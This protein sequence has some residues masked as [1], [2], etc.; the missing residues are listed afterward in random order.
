MQR[1]L[2]STT[3]M[4]SHA[5]A[6][7]MANRVDCR[8]R[9]EL[10]W[11]LRVSW[12]NPPASVGGWRGGDMDARLGFVVLSHS[13]PEL[14]RRLLSAL[15]RA[16]RNPSIVVHHDFSQCSLP[17]DAAGWSTDLQYV[18]PHIQTHWAHV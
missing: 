9:A 13:Q 5:P 10:H 1:R 8:E 3:D 7:A 18:R 15:D 12:R 2:S 11:G 4:R 6:A 14:L 16:Y 17:D